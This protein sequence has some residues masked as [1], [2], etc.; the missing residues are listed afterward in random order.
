M[1]SNGPARDSLLRGVGNDRPHNQ[2]A[3]S[4]KIRSASG[5][6]RPYGYSQCAFQFG[7]NARTDLLSRGH[8]LECGA[9]VAAFGLGA[10]Q[11]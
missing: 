11:R 4:N 1:R 9:L 2:H 10:I 3:I 6:G 5:R 7:L 8:Y